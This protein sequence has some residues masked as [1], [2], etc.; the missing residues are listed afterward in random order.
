MYALKSLSIKLLFLLLLEVCAYKFTN[1]VPIASEAKVETE[2]PLLSS[3]EDCSKNPCACCSDK[4]LS[5]AEE[6]SELN[7]GTNTECSSFLKNLFCTLA[8]NEESSDIGTLSNEIMVL[9]VCESGCSEILKKCPVK[10]S[11][12]EEG[13]DEEKEEKKEKDEK[14]KKSENKESEDKKEEGKN[15]DKEKENENKEEKSES[16]EENKETGENTDEKH[17]KEEEDSTSTSNKR[18][19]ISSNFSGLKNAEKIT[20]DSSGISGSL[21]L[22]DEKSECSAISVPNMHTTKSSKYSLAFIQ[23][24]SDTKICLKSSGGFKLITKNV[25]IL[26]SGSSSSG[27]TANTQTLPSSAVAS[28]ESSSL[29]NAPLTDEEIKCGFCFSKCCCWPVW[30]GSIISFAAYM[31]M[32]FLAIYWQSALFSLGL[33]SSHFWKGGG[34]WLAGSGGLGIFVGMLVG[35]L[36]S[37][38]FAGALSLGGSLT[39]LFMSVLLV[40]RLGAALGGIGGLGTGA[41]IGLM[42]HSGTISWVIGLILGLLLGLVV[43][44]SPIARSLKMNDRYI[45]RGIRQR[46]LRRRSRLSEGSYHSEGFSDASGTDRGKRS[47]V[48]R[49]T[50][51]ESRDNA[52]HISD[53]HSQSSSSAANNVN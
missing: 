18:S 29:G 24:N 4:L 52:A 17:I 47:S 11:K 51:A 33:K 10:D 40:G 22:K 41:S 28:N 21:S 31:V 14:D 23:A 1:G 35:G 48:Q 25:P 15:E 49:H 26:K 36:V 13:G 7:G 6:Y 20:I 30:S 39:N 32:A 43:G 46:E 9:S 44:F 34:Y 53:G 50:S 16:N 45:R 19:I 42:A 8:C 38:C 37:S 5:M 2:N 27:T 12:S 3:T